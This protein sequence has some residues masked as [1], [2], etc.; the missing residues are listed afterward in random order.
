M[1]WGG[2]RVDIGEEIV[3]GCY[4]EKGAAERDD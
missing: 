1:E 3:T 2:G 4:V